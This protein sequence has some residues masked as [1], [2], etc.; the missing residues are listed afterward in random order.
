MEKAVLTNEETLKEVVDCLKE[1]ISINTKSDF[2]Y[3][4]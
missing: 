2:K 1:N 4:F 3:N